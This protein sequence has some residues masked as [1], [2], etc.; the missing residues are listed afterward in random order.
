VGSAALG[1][2]NIGVPF[3]TFAVAAAAMFPMGGAAVAAIRMGRGD[4]EGANHAFMT[5]VAL[6][7]LVSV[8]LTAAGMMFCDADASAGRAAFQNVK[9]HRQKD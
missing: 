6:T 2:V 7:L 4:R 3:I 1:A 5:S 8:L 9:S